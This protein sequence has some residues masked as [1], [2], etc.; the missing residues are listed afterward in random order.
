MTQD[1]Y[2]DDFLITL[3]DEM[4]N[5]YERVSNITSLGFN[6][7]W[8]RQLIKLMNLKKGMAV[9]DLM[10]GSGETWRYILP[11]IDAEGELWN[12]D[13]SSAMCDYAQ[14]RLDAIGHDAVHIL[15][16]NV[17]DSSIPNNHIDAVVCVYGIK[18]LNPTLYTSL[19]HEARRI[20]KHG[21]QIGLVEISMPKWTLLRIPYLGYVRYLVPIVGATMLGNHRNYRMLSQYMAQFQNSRV[22]ADVFAENG[23]DIT[24]HEF[25]FGC[26]TA[27][28]GTFNDSSDT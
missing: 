21:G 10:G 8:R 4:Q 5:T 14:V 22:L 2:E 3:F 12:V 19:V 9:A 6:L 23:F 25:F 1:I 7:R 13:F 28:T 15:Q 20:L 11:E 18:T 24:Y 26:G 27:I 16:E 17:F